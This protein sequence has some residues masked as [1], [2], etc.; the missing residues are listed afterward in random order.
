MI[1]DPK[2]ASNEADS[3]D[4]AQAAL[5]S[6]LSADDVAVI[7]EFIVATKD[8]NNSASDPCHADDLA[9]LL[10]MDLAILGADF[11]RFTA[12]NAQIRQEYTWV[13]KPIYHFKRRQVLQGFYAKERLFLSDEFY[14]RLEKQ[15]KEN[16]KRVLEG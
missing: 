10:D 5:M 13:L 8:H 16:L 9:Y 7:S 1:Y 12:Y 6:K 14:G 11:E 15:A 2:S 3:A 4:F